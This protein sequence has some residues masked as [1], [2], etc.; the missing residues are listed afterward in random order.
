MILPVRAATTGGGG[1]ISGGLSRAQNP[2]QISYFTGS[3]S[4]VDVEER[5][6]YLRYGHVSYTFSTWCHLTA[7][8]RWPM[9]DFTVIQLHADVNFT[10]NLLC[11]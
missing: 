10:R 9:S 11:S 5:K 7:W 2:C 1:Q 4:G 6:R 8:L 3:K